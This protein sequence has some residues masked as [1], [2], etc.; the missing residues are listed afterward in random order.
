MG[1]GKKFEAEKAKL[2]S[3]SIFVSKYSDEELNAISKRIPMTKELFEKCM[4]KA[5][6]ICD[7]ENIKYLEKSYTNFSEKSPALKKFKTENE[8]P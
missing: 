7:I 5:I 4:E 3:F 2:L 6:S 8:I 1:N